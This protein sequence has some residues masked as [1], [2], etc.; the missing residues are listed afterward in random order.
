MPQL[1]AA[2]F[3]LLGRPLRDQNNWCQQQLLRK[4]CS[5]VTEASKK[6]VKAKLCSQTSA[7]APSA[8]GTQASLGPRALLVV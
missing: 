6:H 4:I 5:D 1:S 3:T 8:N 2:G 7:D